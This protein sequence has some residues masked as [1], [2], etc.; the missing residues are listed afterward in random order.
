[1]E[2]IDSKFLRK[3]IDTYKPKFYLLLPKCEYKITKPSTD[4]K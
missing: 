1:M 2:R 3:D 4:N